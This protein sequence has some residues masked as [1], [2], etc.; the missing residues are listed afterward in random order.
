MQLFPCQR[1]FLMWLSF[2]MVLNAYRPID[3]TKSD[4]LHALYVSP[5]SEI[6]H[7]LAETSNPVK[8]C[9]LSEQLL[10]MNLLGTKIYILVLRLKHA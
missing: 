10:T 2:W 6:I 8:Q 3:S 5:I 7:R 1:V 9:W 4:W